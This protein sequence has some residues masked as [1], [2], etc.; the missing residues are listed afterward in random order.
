M[1]KEKDLLIGDFRKLEVD[2]P[3]FTFVKEKYR[4]FAFSADVLHRFSIPC[5]GVKIDCVPGRLK[6]V[7]FVRNVVGSF[8]GQCSEICGVNHS[9]M[10]INLEVLH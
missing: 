2:S 9:F 7:L 8:Y 10:P 5:L 4:M 1:V 6:S 3:L